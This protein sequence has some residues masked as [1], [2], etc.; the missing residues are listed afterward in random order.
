[1]TESGTVALPVRITDKSVWIGSGEPTGTT[2]TSTDGT[3]A[4]WF[5]GDPANSNLAGIQI[6]RE[7]MGDM[8]VQQF[9]AGPFLGDLGWMVT[10]GDTVANDQVEEAVRSLAPHES[11]SRL[12]LPKSAYER[13]LQ[14]LREDAQQQIQNSAE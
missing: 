14:W 8:P 13:L 10:H 3:F 6:D 9:L 4:F 1:M 11:G 2:Y 7:Q 12:E 5:T